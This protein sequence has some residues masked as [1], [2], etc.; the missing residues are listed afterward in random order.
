MGAKGFVGIGNFQPG[1]E[2]LDVVTADNKRVRGIASYDDVHKYGYFHRVVHALVFQD[3]TLE[4]LL[5]PMRSSRKRLGAFRLHSSVAGHMRHREDATK[6]EDCWEAGYREAGEEIFY[7]L[8]ECPPQFR[9][10]QDKII[11]QN[12]SDNGRNNEYAHILT[13]VYEGPFSFNQ[14]EIFERTTGWVNIHRI[15]EEIDDNILRNGY[16]RDFRNV[17]HAWYK[18]EMYRRERISR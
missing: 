7:G 9:L 2:Y 5:V 11:I 18:R 10:S 16:T 6:G 13:A 1:T 17:F 12:N 3:E 8:D 4:N 14:S 15:K